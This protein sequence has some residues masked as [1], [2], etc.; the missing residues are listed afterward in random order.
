MSE[1]LNFT[2]SSLFLYLKVSACY[3]KKS[4]S[5]CPFIVIVDY[6]GLVTP[7]LRPLIHASLTL[8]L[9]FKEV[10]VMQQTIPPDEPETPT[11]EPETGDENTRS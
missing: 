8:T 9:Y 5:H 6:C 11:P 4:M 10:I 7:T 2:C 1:Y 3:G